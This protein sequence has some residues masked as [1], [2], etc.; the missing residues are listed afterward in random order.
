MLTDSAPHRDDV[1][2]S[3]RQTVLVRRRVID[4]MRTARSFCRR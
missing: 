1:C 4:L 3:S 2:M